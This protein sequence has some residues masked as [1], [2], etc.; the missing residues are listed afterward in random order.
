M[1]C[2]CC[3][4]CNHEFSSEVTA[5]ILDEQ[6]IRWKIYPNKGTLIQAKTIGTSLALLDRAL[7]SVQGSDAKFTTLV[8]RIEMGDDGAIECCILVMRIN[9]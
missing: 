2:L 5:R 1:T 6:R 9:P 4:Q 3:P 8:E 7:R